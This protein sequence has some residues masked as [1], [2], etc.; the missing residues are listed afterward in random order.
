[1]SFF[2]KNVMFFLGA[3]ARNNNLLFNIYSFNKAD[4]VRI[5]KEDTDLC[6]EGFQ[7]SGSSFFVMILRLQNPDIQLA[8]HMHSSSHIAKAIQQKTPVVVLVR[9]PLD[10]VASLITWDDDLSIGRALWGYRRFHNAI[11]KHRESIQ[12]VKFEDVTTDTGKVISQINK[13]WGTSFLGEDLTSEWLETKRKQ[14]NKKYTN[15][16]NSPVPNHIKQAS[17]AKNKL[18]ISKHKDFQKTIKVYE[19]L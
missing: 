6:I 11:M 4:Q 15:S 14:I 12:F 13:R 18:L 1:M 8:H 7:R 16:L 10:A 3:I 17:N 2:L 5:L 19:N 9:N